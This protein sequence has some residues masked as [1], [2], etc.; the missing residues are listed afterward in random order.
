MTIR[1]ET[2]EDQKRLFETAAALTRSGK[3]DDA[4]T[5]Y[6]YLLIQNPAAAQY[7]TAGGIAKMKRGYYEEACAHF[8]I[9]EAGEEANPVPIM[10][11]GICLMRMGCE[12][13]ALIALRR[14]MD[15]AGDKPEDRWMADAVRRFIRKRDRAGG[16]RNL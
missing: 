4:I 2:F 7:W 14:A 3:L 5:I 1:I 8:Q 13:G 6:D 10:M 11:R 12:V 15:M 9:A 16:S